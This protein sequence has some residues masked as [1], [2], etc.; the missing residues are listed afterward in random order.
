MSPALTTTPNA[1]ATES[2]QRLPGPHGHLQLTRW[3]GRSP[4]V[5]V[6]YAES[7]RFPDDFFVVEL[8]RDDFQPA[9]DRAVTAEGRTLLDLSPWSA[10]GWEPVA[11][12]T[13]VPT[14]LPEP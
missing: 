4:R 10:S 2:P 6:Y 9:F 14:M 1:A 8:A 3:L 5:E 12:V 11:I 7:E 13:P